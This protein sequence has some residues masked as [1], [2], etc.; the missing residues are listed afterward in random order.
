[1]KIFKSAAAQ[2][3]TPALIFPDFESLH[4]END[5]PWSFTGKNGLLRLERGGGE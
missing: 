3:N 5:L 2:G 4:R 1:M